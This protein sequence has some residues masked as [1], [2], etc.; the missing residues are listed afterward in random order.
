MPN[1]DSPNPTPTPFPPLRLP[2]SCILRHRAH[3]QTA[4]AQG[5]RIYHPH[6]T[7]ILLPHP[8]PRHKTQ[9]AFLIT[10][11][12]TTAVLRNRL[13]RMFR[14]AWRQIP[15]HHPKNSI[16]LW[17]IKPTASSLSLG[18]IKELMTSFLQPT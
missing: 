13:R 8:S 12:N 15:R 14:E 3:L 7:L 10:K 4:L 2:R 6:F 1:T 17:I 5:H 11:K 9:V 16:T 18:Q